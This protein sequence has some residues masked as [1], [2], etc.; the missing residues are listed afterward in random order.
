MPFCRSIQRSASAEERK[1]K[2][3]TVSTY[4]ATFHDMP[5]STRSPGATGMMRYAFRISILAICVYGP[6]C[7][8]AWA[9]SS[10]LRYLIEQWSGWMPSFTLSPSRKDKSSI[11]LHLPGVWPLGITLKRL[12]WTGGSRS[13]GLNGPKIL[14]AT[15]SFS[16]YAETTSGW[17]SADGLFLLAGCSFDSGSQ[18]AVTPCRRPSIMYAAKSW[19][20]CTLRQCSHASTINGVII[21]ASL[22]STVDVDEWLVALSCFSWAM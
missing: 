22:G 6:E 16:M 13:L 14:P 5:S 17:S 2:G 4:T 3:R 19:S 12:I 10:I 1:P 7:K 8:S 18:P 20:G 11:S 9:I 15:T 21:G